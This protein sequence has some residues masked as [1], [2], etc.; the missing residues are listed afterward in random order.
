MLVPVLHKTLST[1]VIA[2]AALSSNVLLLPP[3]PA[4]SA[5]AAGLIER[6]AASISSSSLVLQVAATTTTTPTLPP[7]AAAAIMPMPFRRYDTAG[8][9]P[10]SMYKQ[11][12]II[13]GRVVKVIDGDTIRIRHTPLYPLSQRSGAY[14]GKLSE[15]TV[16]VRLYG[17]DAPETAKFGN[18]DQPYALEAKDYVARNVE[19]QMVRVKLLR[20]DQYAR[21]VGKVTVRNRVLPFLRTDLTKGLAERGYATLYTGGG[22]E[23]DGKRDVLERKI[24]R[25]QKKRRGIWSNGV[26]NHVDPAAYKRE[27]KARN[28]RKGGR[29]GSGGKENSK[30]NDANVRASVY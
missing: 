1:L 16:S 10:K 20:K 4:S 23:Y 8:D 5:S 21:A 27:I 12:K 3:L 13:R 19:G 17:V 11:N 15:C 30:N 22:A 26:G 2:S 6:S 7:T 28:G 24:A 9:I 14:C 18:P 25:A 29:G